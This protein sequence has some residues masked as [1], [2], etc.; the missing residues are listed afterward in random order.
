[1]KTLILFATKYG[2]VE[3]VAKLIEKDLM[4]EVT[5]VNVKT[6]AVPNLESF[7]T[8]VIGGSIHVGQIQKTITKWIE[9]NLQPLLKKRI[10]LFL[11]AGH[12]DPKMIEQ[13]LNS[14]FDKTL[15]EHAIVKE[16]L[17]YEMIYDDM[18]FFDKFIIKMVTKS[19]A[20]RS[21]IKE[22][23]IKQFAKQLNQ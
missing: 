3:K 18:N 15:F 10:G 1:M 8:I 5:L 16:V 7:D 21:E 14:A 20:N 17:G 23:A 12:V 13:E 11:C 6:D 9:S 19:K 2:S 4:G 22:E